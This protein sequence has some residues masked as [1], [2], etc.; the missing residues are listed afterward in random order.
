M[1]GG[2]SSAIVMLNEQLGPPAA[3]HK[4]VV[5]PTSN[6]DPEG[7]TQVTVPQL[8][9]SSPPTPSAMG[10]KVTTLP[11]ELV[12]GEVEKKRSDGHVSVQDP[13]MTA[14]FVVDE[15]FEGIPSLDMPLTVAVFVMVEPDGALTLTSKVIETGTPGGSGPSEHVTVPVVPGD[16]VIQLPGL[17]S[18]T[19]VEP[20]CITSVKVAPA[21]VSGPLFTTVMA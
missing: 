11:Q 1:L 8:A 14:V 3:V 6:T 15:L 17:D 16:G 18:E 4:T 19:N 7:G 5:V 10:A 20:G 2:V 12:V 13:A 9:G 21:S